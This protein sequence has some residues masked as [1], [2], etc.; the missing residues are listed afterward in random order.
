MAL[1]PEHSGDLPWLTTE[2][3]REVRRAMVE[4][5]GISPLQMIENA[6]RCTADLVRRRCLG[7]DPRGSHVTALV[8]SG[9]KASVVMAAARRL[10]CWGSDVS[11]RLMKPIGE[12]DGPALHQASTLRA[13]GMR[14]EVGTPEA[15]RGDD[16]IIDGIIGC[17]LDGP[18]RGRAAESIEWI[19]ERLAPVLCIEVPSGLDCVSGEMLRP[20]V[21]A[22]GTLA[23]G[24]PNVILR[25]PTV[26]D[27]IGELYLADI[28]VP[29]ELYARDP[30]NMDVNPIFA[31][32]DLLRIEAG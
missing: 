18:P 5:L 29:P 10:A 28:G 32:C 14:L 11:V 6:G 8:G 30:L 2:Q 19:N 9:G 15:P 26:R 17:G 20:I 31:V 25:S 21:R 1:V 22:G 27:I 7:T 13:M 24:L 23:L 3:S 12:L 4:E 16:L